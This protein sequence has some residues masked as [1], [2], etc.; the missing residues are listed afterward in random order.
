MPLGANGKEATVHLFNLANG[1][2]EHQTVL[3]LFL[4]TGGRGNII[5]IQRI[6]NPHLYQQYIVRKQKMDRDNT[7]I[8]NELQLFHGTAEKNINDINAT[9]FNRSFGGTAHGKHRIDNVTPAP[10]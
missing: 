2:A 8:N 1:S 9:G 10:H 5:K 3:N 7:G 6:Q 4:N